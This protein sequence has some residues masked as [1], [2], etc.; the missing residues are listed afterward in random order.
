MGNKKLKYFG[1]AMLI[2]ILTLGIVGCDGDVHTSRE[3]D[4]K[5]KVMDIEEEAPLPEI[6]V[7]FN[8]QQKRTDEEG[9]VNFPNVKEGNYEYQVSTTGYEEKS[10]DIVVQEDVIK[11]IELTPFPYNL[12]FLIE[13]EKGNHIKDALVKLNGREKTTGEDGEVVFENVEEKTYGYQV[14]RD[15]FKTKEDQIEIEEDV[16]ET[17][18][19]E[20]I[21]ESYFEIT[22]NDY[23]SEV[24][25]G[26]SIEVDYTVKNFGSN[27]DTQDI[28]FYVDGDL[29][30]DM[31]DIELGTLETFEGS[32]SYQVQDGDAPEIVIEVASEDD[33]VSKTISVVDTEPAFF[34]ILSL[35]IDPQKAIIGEEVTITADIINSGE[36][37]K[38][39][40]IKLYG[41]F[42]NGDPGLIDSQ[43]ITLTED[44]LVKLTFSERIE[45]NITTGDYDI[46]CTTEE[47]EMS[48]L[49]EV[50]EIFSFDIGS[51]VI[52]NQGEPLLIELKNVK[53]RY[54]RSYEGT[55][56]VVVKTSQ[57]TGIDNDRE[58]EDV[59]F[60]SGEA[61]VE[62]LTAEETEI[63]AQS[64][65]S[66]PV[67]LQDMAETTEL[68]IEQIVSVEKSTVNPNNN[69]I[70]STGE[71]HEVVITVNDKAG[72]PIEINT[73]EE[74]KL[75]PGTNNI[76]DITYEWNYGG[77][78]Q[79]KVTIEAKN[80]GSSEQSIIAHGTEL[81]SIVFTNPYNIDLVA[82]SPINYQY[83]NS[84]VK[85]TVTDD[86]GD[87]VEGIE[88]KFTSDGSGYFVGGS[89]RTTNSNG[90]GT[91]YYS[92]QWDDVSD[93]PIKVFGQEQ[94]TQ[95]EAEALI[96]VTSN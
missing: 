48:S 85:A 45:E 50:G 34:E 58:I 37:T 26:E 39:Q 57:L 11:E 63:E 81:D 16:N 32:F 33:Q 70:L 44:E 56:D 31:V 9:I 87:P 14:I 2:F 75:E 47:D 86:N 15:H 3:Y 29:E 43:E 8:G 92:A 22:I 78:N 68:T 35:E 71:T 73:T 17:V 40:E 23:T 84:T 72:D 10:G 69:V 4:V 1:L 13:D 90:K 76:V 94:S 67:H 25:E 30:Y 59:V 24:D 41:D 65:L 42:D 88:V 53:G 93:S 64:D 55:T 62:T 96:E 61:V 51:P 89:S 83:E 80:N 82:E 5:I 28:K 18:T 79:V 36:V 49:L 52:I 7:E 95:Q 91:V 21:K 6:L 27:I 60:N 54:N 19:L 77:I 20:H 74:L 46:I 38:S 12:T 66:L